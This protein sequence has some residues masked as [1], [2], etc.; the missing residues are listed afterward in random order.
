VFNQAMEWKSLRVKIFRRPFED[1]D[2]RVARRSRPAEIPVKGLGIGE[3]L[4]W[5]TAK[6]SGKPGDRQA[7]INAEAGQRL[8]LSG[9]G[10][11]AHVLMGET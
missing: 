11:A 7:M 6:L 1:Q 10:I 4:G 9:L 3:Q 2:H 5:L 8:P